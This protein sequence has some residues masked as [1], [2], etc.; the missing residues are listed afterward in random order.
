[1]K[2]CVQEIDGLRPFK[3]VSVIS[4]QEECVNES[5]YAMETHLRLDDLRPN[6]MARRT[7]RFYVFF[8]SISVIAG[9]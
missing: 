2:R 8:N 4:G 9:R 6:G 5:P 3:S 7:T 1:M